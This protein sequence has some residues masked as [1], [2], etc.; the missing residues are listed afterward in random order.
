V[1]GLVREYYLLLRSVLKTKPSVRAHLTR[2]RHCGIFF[3]TDPRNAGRK[4]LGCPFGCQQAHRKR[5]STQRSVA[6]YQEP[7]GKIKKAIQNAKR[8]QRSSLAVAAAS[9]PS[10]PEPVVDHVRVVVSLIEGRP[11]SR[12]EIL[13]ML[14]RGLRQHRM[15]R[16]RRIDHTVGWLNAHPP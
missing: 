6:Y 7:E 11:V 15:V 2:C 13:A 8:S 12:P 3:L 4:D 10:P 9:L 14:A 16:R 1:A 5:R